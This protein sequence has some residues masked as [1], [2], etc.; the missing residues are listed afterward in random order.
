[1]RLET[2]LVVDDNPDELFLTKRVLQKSELEIN[3]VTA[4]SGAEALQKLF[5]PEEFTD[6]PALVLLDMKMPG[7]NGL[8]TLHQIRL[9]PEFRFLPVVILTSSNLSTDIEESY[10][11]GASGFVQKSPDY[12]TYS[13][14]LASIVNY[15]VRINKIP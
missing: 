9:K 8:E 12:K 11:A 10:K 7:M 15:W 1:M 3:L 4:N 14:E 6:R 2:I 13:N 5:S